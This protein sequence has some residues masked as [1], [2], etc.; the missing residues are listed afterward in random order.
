MQ[1]TANINGKLKSQQIQVFVL[2]ILLK[3]L[4][5]LPGDYPIMESKLKMILQILVLAST[6]KK[7]IHHTCKNHNG[8]PTGVTVRNTLKL[9]FSDIKHTEKILNRLL[10]SL[11]NRKILRGS[12]IVNS[13]ILLVEYYGSEENDINEIRRS[14]AKNGTT[15]FHGY[16]T[17]YINLKGQRYTLAITYV[18]K[19]DSLLQVLQRLNRYVISYGVKPSLWIVDRGYYTLE[20][21]KWFQRYQK[22][23]L[24][25]VP[26]KG[27]KPNHPKGP[28]ST[29]KLYTYTRGDWIRYT[30]R[31]RKD[32]V[33]CDMAIVV[34]YPD[35]RG[36]YHNPKVYVYACFGL[37]HLR[38]KRISELYKSRF[39]IETSHRQMHEARAK[40]ASKSP[41]LRYLFVGIGFILRNVWIYLHF[42]VLY[43]KRQGARLICFGSLTFTAMLEQLRHSIEEV[44][45]LILETEIEDSTRLLLIA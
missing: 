7:T 19:Q 4:K 22:P 38:L 17:V 42:H 9:I 8:A 29:R 45:P 43:T 10:R 35:G 1:P 2:K 26:Q 39:G 11:V 14:Q 33:T 24:M 6:T 28:S 37:R 32:S 40:T 15:R 16:A 23:F 18:W 13:D 12:P 20:I 21:I 34:T 3:I 41:V 44:C 30:I 36:Q 5:N 27:R 31:S 25:P